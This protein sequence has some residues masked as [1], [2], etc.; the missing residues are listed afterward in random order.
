MKTEI[1]K[2]YASKLFKS[3]VD[4]YPA[5]FKE[6]LLYLKSLIY[7]QAELSPN[8]DVIEESIK[9]RQLSYVSKNR[10]GTPIRLG[11][12][13]KTPGYYGLYVNCSTTVINDVKHIFGDG[14]QYDGNR[15]LLF[16]EKDNLPENNIRRIIDIILCYHI[17]KK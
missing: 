6:K 13:K 4:Q 12:E 1:Q 8:V 16:N 17:N 11:I 15:G 9:W 5:E 2:K 7:E 10:S 14:F 3:V